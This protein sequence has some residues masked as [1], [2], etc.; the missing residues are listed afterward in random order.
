MTISYVMFV[1]PCKPRAFVFVSGV[2]SVANLCP[3]VFTRGCCVDFSS[4][5]IYILD[6]LF[7]RSFDSSFIFFFFSFVIKLCIYNYSCRL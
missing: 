7:V 1:Y 3:K 5:G 2:L 6:L 4:Y